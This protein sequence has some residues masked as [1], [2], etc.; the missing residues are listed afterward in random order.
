MWLVAQPACPLQRDMDAGALGRAWSKLE[1]ISGEAGLPSLSKYVGINGQA[2]E[3]GT[4]AAQVLA[5]V[6][7]LLAAI[8]AS[9]KK[10]PA[11]KA[12]LAALEE[13]RAILQWADQHQARVYFEVEF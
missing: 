7:G 5:A 11:K 9:A 12:T 10:L 2:A 4:P 8:G 3:D 1:S 13:V 6:D